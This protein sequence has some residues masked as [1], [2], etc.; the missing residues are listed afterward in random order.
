MS[1][2]PGTWNGVALGTIHCLFM[3]LVR[4]C[5]SCLAFLSSK[6]SQAAKP[7]Y[8]GLWL[9]LLFPLCMYCQPTPMLADLHFGSVT[10]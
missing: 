2:G 6:K 4:Y 1:S 8:P 9:P 3:L 10:L 5:F 7:A